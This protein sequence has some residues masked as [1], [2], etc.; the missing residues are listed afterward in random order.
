M[1]DSETRT[2]RGTFAELFKAV[3]DR[4]TINTVGFTSYTAAIPGTFHGN[5]EYAQI[6]R[7]FQHAGGKTTPAVEIYPDYLLTT[8]ENLL[9]G[10]AY[11]DVRYD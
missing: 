2:I 3:S 1:Q 5:C 4:P 9:C 10:I 8:V 7:N 6:V 11:E